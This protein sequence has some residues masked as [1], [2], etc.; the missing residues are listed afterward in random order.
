MIAC[1]ERNETSSAAVA[2]P[3]RSFKRINSGLTDESLYFVESP[4]S[5]SMVAMMN[6]FERF[7]EKTGLDA[8]KFS[9]FHFS[10]LEYFRV[11]LAKSISLFKQEYHSIQS[12]YSNYRQELSLFLD[13]VFERYL[14]ENTTADQVKQDLG[15]SD[16]R[17]CT[18]P[19]A[20]PANLIEYETWTTCTSRDEMTNDWVSEATKSP[21]DLFSKEEIDFLLNDTENW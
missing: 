13:A 19:L 6:V 15:L 7:Q 8:R 3:E 2:S 16:E 12:S 5:E 14:L 10:R 20:S 1:E 11:V 4:D 18:T 17:R 9:L 21:D